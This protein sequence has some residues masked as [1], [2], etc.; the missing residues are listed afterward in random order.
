MSWAQL[1]MHIVNLSFFVMA[2]V[3]WGVVVRR[4][5][6]TE[7]TQAFKCV[8][9]LTGVTAVALSITFI[10]LQYDWIVN[11]HNQAVGDLTSYLWLIFDYGLSVFMITLG[12]WSV[13]NINLIEEHCDGFL[14]PRKLP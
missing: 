1:W 14:T 11:Q 8:G 5:W 10:F 2:A 3:L 12:V 4:V 7:F 13:I 9:I 6:Q